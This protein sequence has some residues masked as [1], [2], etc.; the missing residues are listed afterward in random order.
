SD[1]LAFA[2]GRP[3]FAPAAPSGGDI[4]ESAPG[5][6]P[7][8]AAPPA[9]A[10]DALAADAPVRRSGA[11]V[12]FWER[13]PTPTVLLV[14]VTIGLAVLIGVVLGPGGRPSPVFA[15]E[16]GLS[17]ALARRSPGGEDVDRP[18]AAAR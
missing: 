3:V 13:V 15:R 9:Q 18:P 14:P 7:A 6:P 8:D 10:A 1:P 2:S 4:A 12:D 5:V 17:R 16:G 11:A